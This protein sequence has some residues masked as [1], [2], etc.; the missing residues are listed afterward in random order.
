MYPQTDPSIPYF[1]YASPY[2]QWVYDSSVSGAIVPSGVYNAQGQFLTRESGIMI[3]FINGRVL[4]TGQLG[5]G[6]SGTFSRKEYNVYFSTDSVT[7]LFLENILNSD[8]NI[9][10]S[11]TGVSPLPFEAPCVI[12][13]E[14]SSN[15]VPFAFGGVDETQNTLRC[16]VI[17]NNNWA[18]TAI[19]SLLADAAHHSFP[20]V[21]A[22]FP[23]I[24]Q[25]GD[26]KS[27]INGFTGYYYNYKQ[28]APNPSIYINNM[29][30][31]KINNQTNK[32]RIMSLSSC[33]FDVSNVRGPVNFC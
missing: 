4:S 30:A 13:T 20:Q 29:Y 28:S 33:E 10:Y 9:A 3:D 12:V 14:S 8:K 18:Q 32:N 17:S 11:P 7:D 1:S 2:K 26:L 6:L 31:L 22:T 27:G 15:N 24:S 16:F 21:S 19:N 5:N 25:Y 23:P